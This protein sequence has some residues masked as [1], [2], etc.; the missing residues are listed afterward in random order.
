MLE[1]AGGGSEQHIYLPGLHRTR[2]IV[3]RE[4][5]GSFM[6]SDFTYADLAPKA[7]AGAKHE[8]LPDEAIDKD[9]TYVLET[10]PSSAEAAGYSKVRM[11]IRKGDF[12]ALRTRFYDD[13]GKVAK[14]LY[15]RRTEELDGKP[16]V[17]QALMQAA[18]G[19]ATEI[20]VDA[21][22]RKKQE[23]LPD[24]AFTPTALER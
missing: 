9:S 4:R 3:G 16:V 10:T 8:R 5:E 6:G 22:E 23:D 12:V 1:K 19:H 21:I 11:W 14:T 20:F 24:A 2:R 15:V 17:M 18:N 13:A 7:D